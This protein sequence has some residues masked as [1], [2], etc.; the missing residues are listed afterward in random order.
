MVSRSYPILLHAQE[1]FIIDRRTTDGVGCA[2]LWQSSDVDLSLRVYPAKSL[3]N[4]FF[5]LTTFHLSVFDHHGLLSTV[6]FN[7]GPYNSLA[8]SCGMMDQPLSSLTLASWGADKEE[9]GLVAGWWDGRVV[10][11]SMSGRRKPPILTLHNMTYNVSDGEGDLSRCRWL[12]PL[13]RGPSD[14]DE[15]VFAGSTTM[16][17]YCM[18]RVN[19]R[20]SS[21]Q[22][23]YYSRPDSD[24][25]L[26][27]VVDATWVAMNQP[28]SGKL[29]LVR[30]LGS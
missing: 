3:A 1:I 4:C 9:E 17:Y 22:M 13:G 26:S 29:R 15:L 18:L 30:A 19:P 23:Q 12:C 10:R 21:L 16:C 11:F 5:S 20:L 24:R 27:Q 7:P 8:A 28:S 25:G 6:S 14:G 2:V